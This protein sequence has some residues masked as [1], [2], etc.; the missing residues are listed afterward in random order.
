M[1]SGKPEDHRRAMEIKEAHR[2]EA[3]VLATI[4]RQANIP[5]AGQFGLDQNNAPGHPSFCTGEW[6]LKGLD[7]GEQYFLAHV[8]GT[9]EPEAGSGPAGCVAYESPEPDLAFLN[10]LAVLPA[11][12]GRGLG[13]ALVSHIN[14][15]ARSRGKKKIS[16]GIIKAHTTLRDWYAGLGFVPAGTKQFAHLPF[17]VLFMHLDLDLNSD[18]GLDR[19]LGERP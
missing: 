13:T 7:R 11:F 3:D 18:L 16:I 6:I 1:V 2:T 15:L 17:D 5:V 8:Q 14:A 12:Q 10:R 9:G 19:D 4:V